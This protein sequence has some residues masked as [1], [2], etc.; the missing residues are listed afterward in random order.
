MTES[1]PPITLAEIIERDTQKLAKMVEVQ[2]LAA[3]LG[4][5]VMAAPGQPTSP[6][7]EAPL[8]NPIR[9]SSGFDGTVGG[10]VRSYQS[11][12]RSTYHQL[13]FAVRKHYDGTLKRLTDDI[14]SERVAELDATKIKHFYDTNWAAKGKLAMG[15]TM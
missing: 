2:R 14:G 9:K 10:L 7:P 15:H 1:S 5:V 3:E 13:K 12:K 8:K 11:E 6:A 4:L